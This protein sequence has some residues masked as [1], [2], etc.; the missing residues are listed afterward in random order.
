MLINTKNVFWLNFSFNRH[1][2]A[3]VN[4]NISPDMKQRALQLIDEGWELAEVDALGVSAKS[5]E[6]WES[7]TTTTVELRDSWMC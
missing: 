7:G 6:R 5:I 2:D 4:R 3:M 1:L